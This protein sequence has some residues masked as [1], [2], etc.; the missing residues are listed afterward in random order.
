MLNKIQKSIGPDHVQLFM[1]QDQ[2]KS[3]GIP[4]PKQIFTMWL[5]EVKSACHKWRVPQN[6]RQALPLTFHIELELDHTKL[7]YV[8]G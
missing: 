1:F 4:S 5:Q 6:I 7:W 3:L 8:N 2:I